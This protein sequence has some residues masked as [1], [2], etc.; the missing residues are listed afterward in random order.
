[1]LQAGTVKTCGFGC[2]AGYGGGPPS[3][4]GQQHV[5]AGQLG[6]KTSCSN[7]Q[8]CVGAG[9][10]GHG[11]NGGGGQCVANFALQPPEE[12]DPKCPNSVVS[13]GG[14]SYDTNL[15]SVRFPHHVG[16]GGG[17]NNNQYGGGGGIIAI[18]A[19]ALILNRSSNPTLDARGQSAV[20]CPPSSRCANEGPSASGGGSGGTVF[21]STSRLFG[22]G[23]IDVSGGAGG[24]VTHSTS[25]ALLSVGGGGAGGV[26]WLDWQGER[27]ELAAR[28]FGEEPAGNVSL[29]GGAGCNGLNFP[30]TA[31]HKSDGD[32]GLIR[33]PPCPAGFDG[34][35]C[36]SECRPCFSVSY[37]NTQA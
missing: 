12:L 20:S 10:G 18:H 37:G 33:A 22:D 3:Q 29:G 15:S 5:G 21:I 24:L 14:K 6:E 13:N 1:M 30:H 2:V 17:G 8:P 4:V 32:S 27:P 11:G 36:T 19:K 7:D 26:C 16:S 28:G 23:V 31:G 35:V 25:N 34:C 9:G